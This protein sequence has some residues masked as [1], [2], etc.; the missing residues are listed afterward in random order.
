MVKKLIGL[1]PGREAVMNKTGKKSLS[2]DEVR[3]QTN[4]REDRPRKRSDI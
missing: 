1:G 3:P 2:G 4:Q